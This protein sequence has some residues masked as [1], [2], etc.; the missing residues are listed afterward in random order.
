[1]NMLPVTNSDDFATRPYKQ[2][3]AAYTADLE[4]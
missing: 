4:W 1:V 3:T 2:L